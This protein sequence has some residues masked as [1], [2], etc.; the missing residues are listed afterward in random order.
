MATK[1]RTFEV[2]Y[3]DGRDTYTVPVA[4]PSGKAARKIMEAA[5]TKFHAVK[6]VKHI[7]HR[8]IRVVPADDD[9]G[10]VFESVDGKDPIRFDTNHPS[11]PFLRT[12]FPKETAEVDE[13]LDRQNSG[14]A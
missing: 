6:E 13:Y 11:Q 2:T 14:D 8:S 9:S 10:T 12:H 1:V 7:G 5:L 3:A 4:A